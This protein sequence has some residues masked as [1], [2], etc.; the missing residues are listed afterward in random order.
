MA[1]SYSK[2]QIFSFTPQLLPSLLQLTEI[3]ERPTICSTTTQL[4]VISSLNVNPIS[5]LIPLQLR[6]WA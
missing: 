3:L 5:Y 2:F 6:S 4:V 1:L